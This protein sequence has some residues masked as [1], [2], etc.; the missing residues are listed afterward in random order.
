MSRDTAP[1]LAVNVGG[2]AMSNPVTVASGTFGY[3]V[4]YADWLD[5][6]RLGAIT[7]K[8]I[9]LDPWPGNPLPRHVEVPGGLVNA[10]GLQGPGVAGFIDQY[11]PRL[12]AF[13]VP[14]IVNI[15]GATIEEYAEVAARLS[16]TEGISGLE[17]NV[18][19]PNVKVGGSAFGA[20]PAT[21][22][23]VVAAVRRRTRL[24]VIP[25]LAPN[26]PAMGPFARAAVEAG[27]DALSLVNTLPAMVID[28][29][30]RRP[31]LANRVGGLSGAG[32]HPVALK[33]V[34]DAAQAVNVPIIAMG[35]IVEAREA[36]AFLIAGA[37]AV[38]VGTANFIDPT[39]PLRVIDGIRDYLIRHRMA[40]V[41]ELTGS[42]ET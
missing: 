11:V 26:V 18:S 38:A 4:E 17:I 20:D 29:E 13:G 15:W 25:K 1:D 12:R 32:L 8:G 14:V 39:T 23:A 36:I 33:H 31:V 37:T 28:I 35:G 2:I 19:C 7:V 34:Y 16:D 27:A 42:L 40:S 24:P 10:I 5:V 41:S 22:A 3:G 6:R 21:M 30:R 9:R